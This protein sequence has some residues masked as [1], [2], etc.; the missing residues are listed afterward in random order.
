MKRIKTEIRAKITSEKPS[1]LMSVHWLT[2]IVGDYDTTGTVQA[3]LTKSTR[4]SVTL[5]PR[6]LQQFVYA[7]L[8]VFT[9]IN[10]GN[11]ELFCE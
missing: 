10:L 3:W 4:R 5:D 6:E 9:K 1:Y 8:S 2:Q 11:D 7:G